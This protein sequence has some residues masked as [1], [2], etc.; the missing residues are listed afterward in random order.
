MAAQ[1]LYERCPLASRLL[2]HYLLC[3]AVFS[4]SLE[5]ELGGII[6]QHAIN[7]HIN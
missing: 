1:I 3:K 5:I 4:L 7:L 6:Q 2:N